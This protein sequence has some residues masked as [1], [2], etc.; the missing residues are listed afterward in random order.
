MFVN[1]AQVI[2][3]TRGAREHSAPNHWQF[4]ANA[5]VIPMPVV[6][7]QVTESLV[8]IEENVLVPGIRDSFDLGMPPLKTYDFVVRAPKLAARAERN[9]RMNVARQ[10]FELLE[11]SEVGILGI[12]NASAAPARDRFRLS[13]RAERDGCAALWAIERAHLR[14][15]RGSREWR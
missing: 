6:L 5:N 7:A 12:E 14:P 4:L 13:E 1:F 9:E 15:G 8:W 2:D 3:G 11:N 10:F